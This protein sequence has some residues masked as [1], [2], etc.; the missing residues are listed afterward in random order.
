LSE[1]NHPSWNAPVNLQPRESTEANHCNW[2]DVGRT[3]PLPQVW[4]KKEAVETTKSKASQETSEG[5]DINTIKQ[6]TWTT[7]AYANF[8]VQPSQTKVIRKKS[9]SWNNE[10]LSN[11]RWQ[12]DKNN[13]FYSLSPGFPT[14]SHNPVGLHGLLYV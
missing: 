6:V 4:S 14:P 7:V 13:Y 11:G 3:T 9:V 12:D 1:T 2:M 10:F 5:A 8:P